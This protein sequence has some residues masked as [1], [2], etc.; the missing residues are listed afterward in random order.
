MAKIDSS[1]G[2]ADLIGSIDVKEHTGVG[3][4]IDCEGMTWIWL[5]LDDDSLGVDGEGSSWCC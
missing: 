3:D 4:C 2:D 1:V 5:C